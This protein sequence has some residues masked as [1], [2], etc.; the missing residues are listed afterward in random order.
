MIIQDNKFLPDRYLIFIFVRHHMT[1]TLIVFYLWQT[2]FASYEESTGS[3][4]YGT[5]FGADFSACAAA[6]IH[7]LC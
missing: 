1:F 3:S 7:P 4:I 6:D 2:N 5:Y